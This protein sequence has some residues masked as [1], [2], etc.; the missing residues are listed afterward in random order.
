MGQ[1]EQFLE[2]PGSGVPVLYCKKLFIYFVS[3]KTEGFF[4]ISNETEC[5]KQ[6]TGRYCHLKWYKL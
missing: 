4:F 3:N 6:R 2:N 1:F 5:L